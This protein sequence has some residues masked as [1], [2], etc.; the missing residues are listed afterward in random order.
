M[1]NT[2]VCNKNPAVVG[3][4]DEATLKKLPKAICDKLYVSG[5]ATKKNTNAL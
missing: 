1:K 3:H 5:F 4:P 2:A